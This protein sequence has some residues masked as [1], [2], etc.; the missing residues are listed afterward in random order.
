MTGINCNHRWEDNIKMT[1]REAGWK[2]IDWIDQERVRWR[3]VVNAA[4]ILRVP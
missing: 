3:T 2:G 1:L 4:I